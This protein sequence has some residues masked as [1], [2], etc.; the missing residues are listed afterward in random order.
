MALITGDGWD[1]FRERIA[2]APVLVANW[3]VGSDN[4]LEHVLKGLWPQFIALRDEIKSDATRTSEEARA[5]FVK[6]RSHLISLNPE[7]SDLEID[8]EARRRSGLDKTPEERVSHRYSWRILPLHTEVAIISAALCEAEINLA[9]AWGLSMLDKEDVFQLIESKPTPEKWL[10]GPKI[11]LP[12][13]VIPPGCAEAETLRRV[14][15]ER[16]RL[17]HPKSTIQKAGKQTLRASTPKPPKLAELLMWIGRYF[18]LPFDL[19]DFLR[20]QPPI[21]GSRFPVLTRRD[22]IERPPQHRLPRPSDSLNS[23]PISP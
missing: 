17:V 11:L 13:Y 18:S 16:N 23:Q 3:H 21:N 2:E 20:T 5:D 8:E 4:W 19:A 1:E 12:D 6:W 9:L 14:F 22:A 15:S 7:A 10:H